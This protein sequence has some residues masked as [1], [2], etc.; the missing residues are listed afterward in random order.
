MVG[1]AQTPHQ[2]LLFEVFFAMNA[3]GEIYHRSESG[4]SKSP[5]C[6][7]MEDQILFEAVEQLQ[8]WRLIP[9]NH[10]VKKTYPEFAM[11]RPIPPLQQPKKSILRNKNNQERKSRVAKKVI[12][13]TQIGHSE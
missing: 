11:N 4:H 3:N 12:I 5:L 7:R 9:T 13:L 1:R 2:R 6:I 10:T 8:S